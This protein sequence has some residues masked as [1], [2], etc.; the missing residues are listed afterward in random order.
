MA[1]EIKDID[2]EQFARLTRKRISQLRVS[3]YGNP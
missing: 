3:D 2:T 1:D